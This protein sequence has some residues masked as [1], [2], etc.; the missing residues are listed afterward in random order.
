MGTQESQETTD[1][2]SQQPPRRAHIV[3]SKN[4]APSLTPTSSSSQ[5]MPFSDGVDTLSMRQINRRPILLQNF[6][7]NDSNDSVSDLSIDQD[8]TLNFSNMSHAVL[9]KSHR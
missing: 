8:K 4:T 6:K 3:L 9:P 7:N 2:S 5:T 1:S